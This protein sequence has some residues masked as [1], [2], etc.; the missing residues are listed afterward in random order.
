[1]I[2]NKVLRDTPNVLGAS[3]AARLF[4][5]T[6]PSSTPAPPLKC[7]PSLSNV[8]DT[9][10]PPPPSLRGPRFDPQVGR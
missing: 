3:V 6:P 8:L 7:L 4:H 2:F 5:K 9:G 10:E 1:M